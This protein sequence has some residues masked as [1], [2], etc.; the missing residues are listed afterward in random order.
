MENSTK[1]HSLQDSYASIVVA[2]V[3]V[4]VGGVVLVATVAVLVALAVAVSM[5]KRANNY[6]T[7]CF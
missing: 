7:S 3:A 2:I 5:R 1:Y 4:V 6:F